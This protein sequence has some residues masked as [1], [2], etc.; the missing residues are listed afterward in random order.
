MD[1]IMG[2][3]QPV[4]QCNGPGT[5]P[6]DVKYAAACGSIMES[7]E[8]SSW[9]TVFGPKSDPASQSIT[10]AEIRTGGH[11]QGFNWS[12]HSLTEKPYSQL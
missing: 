6:L 7:M 12:L 10:P 11:F 1:L 3:Y 8:I 9:P 2:E 5:F 4:A